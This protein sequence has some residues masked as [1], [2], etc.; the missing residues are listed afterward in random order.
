MAGVALGT[1]VTI[2][3]GVGEDRDP[4][5]S[6]PPPECPAEVVADPRRLAGQMLIVRMESVATGS[7][8]R[9]ARRGEIGGV[10]LFPDPQTSADEL[11]GEI[12]K[13]RRAA[14][15]GGA[16]PL[17]IA[18]DQEGGEVKRLADLPPDRP[19]SQIT[20]AQAAAAEGKATGAALAGIGVGVDLAPVVDLAGPESF[21]GSRSFGADPAAVGALTS[22]FGRGL[23][24]AGVTATAKHFPGL[25]LASANTDLGTS[26]V[27]A[28]RARLR[29]GLEPFRL[30]IE[31]GFG[32]VMISN[33]LYPAYDAQ[34]PAWRSRRV[35]ERLLRERLGFDGVIISDDLGAGAVTATGSGEG[36]AAVAAADA[37]VD[38]LLFA[39]SDGDAARASLLDALRRGELGRERL[40][41]SCARV[42]A[43]RQRFAIGRGS[44]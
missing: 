44:P 13:L 11:G 30:A 16:P 27:N 22:A 19:P 17:L 39:L 36:E 6:I 7:L 32:L 34:R 1:G 42:A 37:G 20:T 23:Q 38:L 29:P 33:A 26:V 8:R 14:D 5:A 3:S 31:A 10:I 18:I 4:V 40:I 9:A 2:G 24:S 21:I 12:A 43:L 35:I 25:G 41:E 28:D 15:A